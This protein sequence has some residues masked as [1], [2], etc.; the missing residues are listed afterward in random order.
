MLLHCRVWRDPTNSGVEAG[1]CETVNEG[2]PAIVCGNAIM[3][4]VP[5]NIGDF[6]FLKQHETKN[7]M[8]A[9]DFLAATGCP[10]IRG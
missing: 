5:N 6:H 9:M 8:A 3:T 4:N 10:P 7:K 1:R 2:T